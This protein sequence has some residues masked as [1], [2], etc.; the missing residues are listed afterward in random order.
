MIHTNAEEA[1]MNMEAGGQTAW[2][3]SQYLKFAEE[4]KQ[5]SRDL[6]ARLSGEY[7]RILDLGCGPGNSTAVLQARFPEAEIIGFDSDEN[8]IRK[9]RADHPDIE[10]IRGSAPGDLSRLPGTF[11]LAF[12]NACIHWIPDQRELILA[13]SDMLNACGAFAAQLPLTDEAKFYKTLY[14]L[15]AENWHKIA[16]IHNFHNLDQTGYYNELSRYFQDISIW[17][18]DYYHILQERKDVIEWYRGSG[19]RPYLAA[20][21]GQEQ[22]EFIRDL[23]GA[24]DRS[25]PLLDD[26]RVFLVMPRLFFIARKGE[27]K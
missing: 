7:Q 23:S 1:E 10:F 12:S 24:I 9:A 14:R 22:E 8:M 16:G 18:T 20:L 5:P 3:S 17:E 21:S 11:D 13:V 4:R 19:L 26:G 2:D 15:I 25:Y 27:I 6:I